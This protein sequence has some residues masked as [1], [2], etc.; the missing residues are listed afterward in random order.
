MNMITK[1]KTKGDLVGELSFAYGL[2]VPV[3][4][5]LSVI[6]LAFSIERAAA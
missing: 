4:N 6:E 1:E 3:E 2:F 5:P